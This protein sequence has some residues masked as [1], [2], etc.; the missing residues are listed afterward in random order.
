[1]KEVLDEVDFSVEVE[2]TGS[3][4]SLSDELDSDVLDSEG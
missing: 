1:M 4:R 2:S 3:S